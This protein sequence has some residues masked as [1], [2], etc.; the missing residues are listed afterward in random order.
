MGRS[1]LH[2]DR[3]PQA[4]AMVL[5]ALLAGGNVMAEEPFTGARTQA[6]VALPPPRKEPG[7][8]LGSALAAR[9][10]LREFSAEPFGLQEASQLLWAAQGITDREHGG[11][12]VPSAGA[13]WPLE[14]LLVAGDVT[15]L[16]AGV[17]RYRPRGHELALVRPG[18]RRRELA[19]AAL[20]QMWLADAPAV[21]V[22]AGVYERTAARYG[23]RAERY[24]QMEA[25]HAGQNVCLQAVSLGLGTVVVGAFRDE[26]TRR[27]LGLPE[28]ERPL[29]LMPVG[30]PAP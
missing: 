11:R 12:T 4:G 8:P 2:R 7:I 27:V 10:S 14:V 5:V 6:T 19:S 22:I 17:Y 30:K 3:V 20:A 26:E 16:P 15:G 21:L 23:A 29:S 18:D 13:T 28:D 25:G 9:R 24:V 1:R